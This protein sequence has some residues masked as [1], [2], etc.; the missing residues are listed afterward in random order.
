V[1]S[2]FFSTCFFPLFPP[3]EPPPSELLRLRMQA[4]HYSSVRSLPYLSEVIV[5]FRSSTFHR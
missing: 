2:F 5:F 3:P 1:G 4:R